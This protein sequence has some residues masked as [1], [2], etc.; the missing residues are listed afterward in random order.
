MHSL[1]LV[2][3]F[4]RACAP[5]R[6]RVGA[7]RCLPRSGRTQRQMFCLLQGPLW[8]CAHFQGIR[9]SLRPL[10]EG[11]L[12]LL[13]VLCSPSTRLV[14]PRVPHLRRGVVV[15]VWAWVQITVLSFRVVGDAVDC[16][17]GAARFLVRASRGRSRGR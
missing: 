7:R 6:L 13:S 16:I 2:P 11:F 10:C 9:L 1:R 3:Q 8:I 4:W 14:L 17:S 12:C 5:R 15:P